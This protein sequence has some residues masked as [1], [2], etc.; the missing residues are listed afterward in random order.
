MVVCGSSLFAWRPLGRVTVAAQMESCYGGGL[1]VARCEKGST[2]RVDQAR[3]PLS[4][5]CLFCRFLVFKLVLFK[6]PWR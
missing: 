5:Q 1:S 6:V 4:L 2:A 3:R